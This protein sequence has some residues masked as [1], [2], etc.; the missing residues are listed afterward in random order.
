MLSTLIT[1]LLSALVGL[2]LAKYRTRELKLQQE[3]ANNRENLAAMIAKS[4]FAKIVLDAGGRAVFANSQAE[5]FFSGLEG[6]RV[7]ESF[8]LFFPEEKEIQIQLASG[9][10]G[11]FRVYVTP[12]R[13]DAGPARLIS[14]LD[15][16]QEKELAALRDDVER[17]V[18]HDMK[19]PLNGIIGL[20]EVLLM[21][22]EL[23]DEPR[24]YLTL[25]NGSGRK[26]L[27]MMNESMVLLAIELGT[28]EFPKQRVALGGVVHK[29][30][31]HL[32]H[33]EK[34]KG[35]ACAITLPETGDEVFG[36]DIL[37]YIAGRESGEKRRGGLVRRGDSVDSPGRL[38]HGAF[39]HSQ[40]GRIVGG[41]AAEFF[42]E[43]LYVWQ[44]RGHRP[45]HVY[46]Q[47]YRRNPGR[48]HSA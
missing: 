30:V 35:V 44:K 6:F 43:V 18:R 24:E 12:L 31:E 21:N 29:V 33:L 25:I 15:I 7:G 36:E 10:E 20:S 38:G 27:E 9:E 37:L 3:V 34:E 32:G 1:A 42:R 26:L 8:S 46:R 47:A 16:K 28:Y 5:R 41:G 17:M 14:L 39:E 48:A 22:P 23:S 19:T 11:V 13:W 45:R 4:P 2:Q 40:H